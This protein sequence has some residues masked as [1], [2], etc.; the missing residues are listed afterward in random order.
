[1]TP[2]VAAL[3][4]GG[5]AI[6]GKEMSPLCTLVAH[7]AL[8]EQLSAL[9]KKGWAAAGVYQ[10]AE[11]PLGTEEF[12]ALA[13]YHLKRTSGAGYPEFQSYPYCLLPVEIRALERLG[14]GTLGP[15]EHPLLNSPLAARREAASIELD[16]GLKRFRERTSRDLDMDWA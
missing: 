14:R 16:D 11:R 5:G 15:T 6:G 8:D 2:L 3:N 1:M 9:E 4:N 7:L 10:V 13:D 12:E